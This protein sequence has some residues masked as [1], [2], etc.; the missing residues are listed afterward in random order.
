MKNKLLLFV[1]FTVIIHSKYLY[2]QDF[3]AMSI[4]DN[5][6]SLFTNPALSLNQKKFFNLP[7]VGSLNAKVSNNFSFTD[8][9]DKT[10]D[11]DYRLNTNELLKYLSE[12]NNFF[13]SKYSMD[14]LHW[15]RSIGENDYLGLSFRHRFSGAGSLPHGLAELLFDNPY[16][17][18]KTFDIASTFRFVMWNEIGASYSH[19]LDENWRIGGR[20]KYLSG[21]Q[22]VETEKLSYTV[23]KLPDYYLLSSDVNIKSTNTNYYSSNTR[24]TLIDN[25]GIGIDI[26]AKYQST[27]KRFTA[28]ASISDLGIIYWS[29]S[30]NTITK[31]PN[32][33]FRFDG[34]GDLD[35][36][37]A[38]DLIKLFDSIGTDFKDTIGLKTMKNYS[39]S[40]A[41]P[42]TFQASGTYSID[43]NFSHNVNLGFAWT[44]ITSE[45]LH[46]AVSAGY[47]WLSKSKNWQLLANY[48]YYGNSASGIG[49]GAAYNT[50]GYQVYAAIDNISSS[51]NSRLLGFDIGICFF[52]LF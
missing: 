52:D 10:K 31:K 20:V 26:G 23:E 49:L 14:F 3:I 29:N 37:G 27:D 28:N 11:D 13:T 22:N 8:I 18:Y 5:P 4:A 15:G 34:F 50:K 2:S 47:Y 48:T 25:P 32:S 1:V 45:K 12:S 16:N 19:K 39:Y 24:F 36:I 21:M 7:L 43:K 33:K 38:F 17:K 44:S 6:K 35:E 41:I 9:A 51:L 40:S 42:M 30:I 46:Y